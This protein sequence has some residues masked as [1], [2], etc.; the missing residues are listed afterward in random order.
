MFNIEADITVE[1]VWS[2]TLAQAEMELHLQEVAQT[3]TENFHCC[4]VAWWQQDNNSVKLQ[5]PRYTYHGKLQPNKLKDDKI[6]TTFIWSL[7]AHH[8]PPFALLA[9]GSTPVLLI[10]L[11]LPALSEHAQ[12]SFS[13]AGVCLGSNTWRFDCS[14]GVQVIEARNNVAF[15]Y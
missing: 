5:K 3:L 10:N 4:H 9:R 6:V 2:P 1:G 12:N 7:S 13:G 14:R 15:T 8:I 11:P